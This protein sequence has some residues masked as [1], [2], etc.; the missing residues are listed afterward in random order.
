MSKE[1]LIVQVT[2][3]NGD[4]KWYADHQY[5]NT[6]GFVVTAGVANAEFMATFTDNRSA[7]ARHGSVRDM[8]TALDDLLDN[9]DVLTIS[10]QHL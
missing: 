3:K 1:P 5:V 7:A 4:S 6:V 10:I 9:P 2:M 8:G